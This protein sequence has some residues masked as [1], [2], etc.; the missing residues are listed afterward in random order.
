M[1]SQRSSCRG[2][3]GFAIAVEHLEA[4]FIGAI[5]TTIIV[6]VVVTIFAVS[7]LQMDVSVS[8]Y[9]VSSPRYITQRRVGVSS[10]E[11]VT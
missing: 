11:A 7:F 1:S 4:K 10:P 3:D 5:I 6:V 8:R 2:R 9:C